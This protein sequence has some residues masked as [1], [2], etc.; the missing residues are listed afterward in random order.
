[1]VRQRNV[2]KIDLVLTK[3]CK[4]CTKFDELEAFFEE[5]SFE[6][7]SSDQ[8][9]IEVNPDSIYNVNGSLKSRAERRAITRR[10]TLKKPVYKL[11]FTNFV[12]EENKPQPELE[13]QSTD[14]VDTPMTSTTS[15]TQNI[16]FSDG[17]KGEDKGYSSISDSSFSSTHNMATELGSYL[18]RPVLI[19]SDTWTENNDLN[20]TINPWSLFFLDARIRRKI[21]NYAFMSC[22]LK[23]KLMIN[24][25]PFYYGC[26]LMS[27]LPL[28][29][30]EAGNVAPASGEQLFGVYSQRPHIYF[31]PQ[32]NQGGVLELPYINYKDW[33]NVTSNEDLVDFGELSINTLGTLLNAN[34][35]AGTGVSVQIYAWAEDVK[36]AGNTLALSLQTQDEYE[37][38]NGVISKP[39]SAIARAMN[40]LVDVPVIGPYMT[41][42]SFVTSKFASVASYFGFTNTPVI[43][44]V[45]PFSGKPFA[46]FAS[47]EISIP[48]NKLT[49]DPK[50]EITIDSRVTGCNG[51]DEMMIS[52]IVSREAFLFQT[53]FDS[54]TPVGE[55]ICAMRVQPNMFNAVAAANQEIIQ[56]TPMGHVC[57]LFKYWRGDI[58]F[59]FQFICSQYHR[60]RVRLTWDPLRDPST[61]A[62]TSTSNYTKIV[63]FADTPNFE[64]RVPY[65]QET[66]YQNVLGDFD[67]A[68]YIEGTAPL[69]LNQATDNGILNMR[70]FTE[71]TSPVAN[72]PC[73]VFVSVRA[74]D[75]FELA[76]PDQPPK[77]IHVYQVQSKDEAID[78]TVPETFFESTEDPNINLVYM[79]ESVKSLRQLMRRKTHTRSIIWPSTGSLTF[80]RNSSSHPRMPYYPGYDPN[81]IHTA[82]SSTGGADARYNY[83]SQIPL[84]WMRHCYIGNR[85]SMVW[86]SYNTNTVSLTDYGYTR[87]AAGEGL[88]LSN[89][90][91]T[92]AVGINEPR[93]TLLEVYSTVW[94]NPKA[95]GSAFTTTGNWAAVDA[96]VP[97]YNKYRMLDNNPIDASFGRDDLSSRDD[98]VTLHNFHMMKNTGTLSNAWNTSEE[99]VSI[100]PDFNLIYYINVPTMYKYDIPTPTADQPYENI[101][102]AP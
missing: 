82:T 30:F 39:A 99:C 57:H 6:L 15:S 13:L 76:A 58:I 18:S 75:N 81:G 28:S 11:K 22:K 27:Y 34:S 65:Q 61:F 74:A 96:V 86:T 37:D 72:S 45:K 67:S 21:D 40:Q 14:T 31:Y 73:L 79:G 24:A 101:I 2:S 25:S 94:D 12:S 84:T 49:L 16:E 46:A 23:V 62:E 64:L 5:A 20:Q 85:G 36:L 93:G 92:Q 35:V 70:V 3:I 48:S 59:R 78:S 51:D 80:V 17:V 97:Y 102:F 100:G 26:G 1:M 44:S 19:Y 8:K 42:S 71:L 47:P 38:C 10:L 66:S 83:V 7:Q 77:D 98:A 90:Q 52:N 88:G 87:N 43:E 50:N 95:T 69:A 55:Q 91:S 54:T 32:S 53:S 33:L 41:A 56:F 9:E 29:T 63:D 68:P 60:G 4:L 89:A